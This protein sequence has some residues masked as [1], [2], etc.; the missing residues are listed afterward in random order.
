MTDNTR[1]TFNPL[2]NSVDRVWAGRA[3]G[4]ERTINSYYDYYFS[5]EDARVFIDGLFAPEDELDIASFAYMVRQE[6]QPLYGFWSYNYDAMMMGTRIITGEITIFTRYP[7]RM[8]EL[9]EK[10]AIAR[11]T[12]KESRTPEQSIVSTLR[13]DANLDDQDTINLQKYWG[14][15]QLDRVTTDSYLTNNTIDG[16]NHIFSAHPPFN[17]VILYGTEE[18]ALTPFNAKSTDD[19]KIRDNIDRLVQADINQRS[20]K[21]DNVVSPMKIVLQEVNLVSMSTSY[22]PGGQPLAE[23]YQFIA[24]DYYFSEADLGF[25]RNMRTS[26]PTATGQSGTQNNTPASSSNVPTDNATGGI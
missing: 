19:L 24:R 13:N 10:A 3:S 12:A 20:V 23:S 26:V 17:F 6:K 2:N 14:Y 1:Y 5:G 22:T 7:R 15:S 9:L 18:T 4:Q 21:I 25:I 8:T 16:K 11:S